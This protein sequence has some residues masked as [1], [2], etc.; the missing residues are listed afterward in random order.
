MAQVYFYF[1]F[2][3]GFLLLRFF[4]VTLVNTLSYVQ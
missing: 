3:I 4:S 2:T 1:K